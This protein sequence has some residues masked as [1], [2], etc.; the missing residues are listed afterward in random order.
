ME[1][2]DLPEPKTLSERVYRSLR[3]DI[4][5]FRLK[6]GQQLQEVEIAQQY[7]LSRTPV[8]E[9]LRRLSADGLAVMTTRGTTVAEISFREVLEAYQVRELLEPFAARLAAAQITQPDLDRIAA[10]LGYEPPELPTLT[11][12]ADQLSVDREVHD[13]ILA[14]SGNETV[15]RVIDDMRQRIQRVQFLVPGGRSRASLEEHRQILAALRARDADATEL[16]MREH[17]SRA[18]ARLVT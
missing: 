7:G 9:A 4:L 17:L 14:A 2:Q 6:P 3:E 16:A 13:I 1:R 11:Q 8:R 15:R 18:K 12:M 5:A 10:L